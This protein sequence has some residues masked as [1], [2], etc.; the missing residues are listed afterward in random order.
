MDPYRIILADDHVLIR[1][2]LRK[3][4]DEADELEVAGEAGDGREL[5]ALL[6]RLIAQMVIL[7]LSM[8]NLGGLDAIPEIK[9]THPELKILILTMH[10]EYLRQALSSGADGYLV[11]QDADQELFFAIE[12][13]RQCEVFIS[14]RLAGG[15]IP[16]FDPLTLRE[17]EVLKLIA[18]GKSNKEM[19]EVLFI[20]AR[21]V[22]CHRA[23]ILS[24]LHLKN[25]AELVKYALQEGYV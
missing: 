13:I 20:S 19:G 17:K 9:M 7:D 22:E 1:Q 3:I 6:N 23:A 21:T 12:K 8:P 5:L 18:G 10:K 25:T 2:G 15:R 4:I 24:K 16:L 11:K 14:P